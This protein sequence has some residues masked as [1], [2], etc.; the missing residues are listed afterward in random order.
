MDRYV[1]SLSP[2]KAQTPAKQKSKAA[3]YAAGAADNP[4][5]LAQVKVRLILC[6]RQAWL[7]KEQW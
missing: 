4:I 2:A 5:M 1:A 6:K 3:T 7:L